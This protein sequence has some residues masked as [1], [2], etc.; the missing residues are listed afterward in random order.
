MSYGLNAVISSSQINFAR[1]TS[2]KNL[3]R[4]KFENKK[5]NQSTRSS[6][7]SID[8][9][10]HVA[11]ARHKRLYELTAHNQN[12]CAIYTAIR[13]KVSN[14]P[15]LR[16]FPEWNQHTH[17]HIYILVRR[18]C[19]FYHPD[20]YYA[21][22]ILL[23]YTLLITCH[24]NLLLFFFLCMCILLHHELLSVAVRI[25]GVSSMSL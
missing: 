22:L 7:H 6:T 13:P 25:F 14:G 15:T 3:H 19:L 20:I 16:Q 10:A 12:Q 1:K 8:I 23:N 4:K 9:D 21:F 11:G 24:L 2:K 17:T 18:L 5:S